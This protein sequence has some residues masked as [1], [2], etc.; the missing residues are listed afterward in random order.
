MQ[1]AAERLLEGHLEE[2]DNERIWLSVK[3]L[4][5][6]KKRLAVLRGIR[7][8]KLSESFQAASRRY[9]LYPRQWQYLEAFHGC[10]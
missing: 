6:T 7:Q 4:H 1:T 3:R 8:Q 2:Y 5:R 10:F 9:S